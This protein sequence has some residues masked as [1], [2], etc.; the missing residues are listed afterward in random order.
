MK[1]TLLFRL[2][3]LIICFLSSAGA[4]AQ[5]LPPPF[6][7][8]LDREGIPAEAAGVL[9]QEVGSTRPIISANADVPFHPASTMKL[10]TTYAAL[11][12]LGPAH[13]W[14]TQAFANGQLVGDVLFG[15]LIIK[16]GGDPRLVLENF[17]LFLRQIR[18]SGIRE[19]KGNL[20]LDRSVFEQTPYDS[21][22]F[23]GKPLSPYNALPD[24]LL[25]NHK[26]IRVRFIPDGLARKVRIEFDPAFSD[27]PVL[28]PQ[29]ADGECGDWKNRIMV[30]L[31]DEG[32]RFG[33]DYALACGEQSWLI[34]PYQMT[35][36]YYF[37]GL[38]RQI[39][40][41]LGGK[42]TGNV[43]DGK[44]PPN[45]RLVAEWNSPPLADVVR[46][47]N[48]Y[49]NNVMARQLLLSMAALTYNQPATPERGAQVI[50][51]WLSLKG[52]PTAGLYIDNGS[53]LSREE[54]IPASTMA[55]LLAAAYA[56]PV[57]PEFISSL[58]IAGS[59]GTMRRR[60]KDADIA[61]KAHIKTGSINGVRS[62]AGY[63]LA[64]SGKRY[65]VVCMINHPNA[66]QSRTAQDALL[67][68]VYANG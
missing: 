6:A 30:R 67:K 62:I 43:R 15:D 21:P 7:T 25:L 58:P 17:W 57:M 65:L 37:G 8:E 14:K 9:V 22:S 53:G 18:A 35:N 16:G 19:I 29:L 3:A 41:E 40:R 34:H 11:E 55:R 56:S 26:A 47:I 20:L 27:Y 28:P 42:F 48:K 2:L 63:V 13:T 60:L 5:G 68:W 64:A 4:S 12:L 10:V 54:R 38:F 1:S 49:S 66:D 24:A 33:G 23:D 51:N 59:D 39:W 44:L 32:A 36:T 50:K 31:G 61:G 45:A 52:I 46:D